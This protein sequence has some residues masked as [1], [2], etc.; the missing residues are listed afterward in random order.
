MFSRLP[1]HHSATALPQAIGLHN[2]T[3]G[4]ERHPA[5]HHINATLAAG[6]LVAVI[7]PNGA[8]KST[9]IKALAGLNQPM[10]GHVEG[11][12]GQRVAYLPQRNEMDIS[13]PITVRDMVAMGLWHE[14]GAL[15]GYSRAQR[16]RVTQ[17]LTQVGLVDFGPRG[18]ATLSGGQFQRALFARLILQ[19]APVILLDEPFTGVD[20]RTCR[21]LL[22][23][24][25]GWHAEGRTVVAVL[26]DMEQVRQHFPHAMLLARELVAAGPTDEV[27]T[28]AN[29]SRA[30][31]LTEAFDDEAPECTQ[32]DAPPPASAWIGSSPPARTATATTTEAHP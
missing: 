4:Y 11:L 3:L 16:E 25:H 18:I 8:G 20:T 13:F 21:D 24:M 28:E 6:A 29:L 9:L 10:Q 31:A 27:L 17:A 7:G 30:R 26:H 2:L 15:G 23:L 1:A 5:I 22:A 32:G 14:V 19:N 12:T